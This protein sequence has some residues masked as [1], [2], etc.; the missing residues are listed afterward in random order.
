M[1]P[2]V[3][4]AGRATG[5]GARAGWA[6]TDMARTTP[7]RQIRHLGR[8]RG[9]LSTGGRG[10]FP[11][12]MGWLARKVR[13]DPMSSGEAGGRKEDSPQ[14]HRGHRE[15]SLRATRAKRAVILPLCALWFFFFERWTPCQA[16]E[17]VLCRGDRQV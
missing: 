3:S 12:D 6:V 16:G 8:G 10:K 13:M 2:T 4:M 15:G 9:R 7:E 11:L 17:P 5:A 14:R 1:M